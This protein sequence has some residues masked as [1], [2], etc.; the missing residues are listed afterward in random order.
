MKDNSTVLV[1]RL[2]DGEEI[3]ILK[4]HLSETL[5][6]GFEFV[7]E[8]EKEAP[9]YKFSQPEQSSEFECPLCGKKAKNRL[10]LLSHKRTHDAKNKNK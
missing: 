6:Q 10:G 2:K 5:V 4:R 9:E 3:A 1:R 8:V 7:A